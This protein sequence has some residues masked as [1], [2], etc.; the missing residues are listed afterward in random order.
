MALA[1]QLEEHI[2]PVDIITAEFCLK[3]E[4][5]VKSVLQ[6]L[7]NSDDFVAMPLFGVHVQA[8]DPDSTAAQLDL[9]EV[10]LPKCSCHLIAFA[11]RPPH[12]EL[13]LKPNV[14]RAIVYTSHFAVRGNAHVGTVDRLTDVLENL[15]DYF[16]P[17]SEARLYPLIPMWATVPHAAKAVLIHRDHIRMLHRDTG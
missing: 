3:G 14:I 2:Y 11:E 6:V 17:V 15:V 1:S 8:V 16:L 5:R 7:L 9:P 12:S 13:P 4:L 10:A